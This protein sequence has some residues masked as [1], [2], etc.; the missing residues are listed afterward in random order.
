MATTS[1]D[2]IR[3]PDPGDPFNLVPDLAT[4]ANDTQD[5][6]TLRANSYVGTSG[7]RAANTSLPPGSEWQDTDGSRRRYVLFDGA[8]ELSGGI[9][10][11]WVSCT[12]GTGMTGSAEVRRVGDITYLEGQVTRTAGNFPTA[13]SGE[14]VFYLPPEPDIFRPVSYARRYAGSYGAVSA[15]GTTVS[16]SSTTRTVTGFGWGVSLDTLYLAGIS[17]PSE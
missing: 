9:D 1:P 12:L 6:L 11:G 15:N 4:L 7:Q 2:N 14:S 3:T 5:A 16:I 10:T 13:T 8:W 17:Y